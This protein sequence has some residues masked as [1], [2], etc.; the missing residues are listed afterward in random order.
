MRLG[1]SSGARFK[2]KIGLVLKISEDQETEK[3]F[4]SG[5]AFYHKYKDNPFYQA[6]PSFNLFADMKGNVIGTYE[7][8]GNAL[9]DKRIIQHINQAILVRGSGMVLSGSSD[10]ILTESVHALNQVY[11]KI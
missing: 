1:R 4:K 8:C 11:P 3:A 2:K 7:E 6:M 9:G 10:Y 5:Y